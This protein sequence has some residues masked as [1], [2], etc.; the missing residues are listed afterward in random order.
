M[1]K[2]ERMKKWLKIVCVLIVIFAI[3]AV[4]YF[5]ANDNSQ[6]VGISVGSIAK[7]P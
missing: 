3:L 2:L 5:L 4:Y 1:G 6:M 7:L